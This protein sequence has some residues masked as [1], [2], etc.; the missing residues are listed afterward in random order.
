MQARE[1]MT[2]K[3][4]TVDENTPLRQ[5]AKLLLERGISAVPVV[6]AGGTMIGMV[7]EGDLVRPASVKER[8]RQDW[9]LEMLAAGSSLSPDF[10]AHVSSQDRAAKDVMTRNVISVAED[11]PVAQIAELLEKH[12]IKRVPVLKDGRIVGIVS[13][14]NL[15]HTLISS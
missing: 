11:T 10:V 7:S 1:V 4:V 3:V 5:I 13:R 2:I 9:W 14:A 8:Q 15:L 6:D 12:R